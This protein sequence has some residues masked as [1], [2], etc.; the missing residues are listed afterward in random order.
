LGIDLNVNR[1][2]WFTRCMS[3]PYRS[4]AVD[5]VFLLPPSVQD[6]VPSEHPCHFVRDLVHTD[7]RQLIIEDLP[8][9]C[10]RVEASL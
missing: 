1:L 9:L 7:T 6:F 8:Q 3:K 2:F 5:Q 4:W 10:R